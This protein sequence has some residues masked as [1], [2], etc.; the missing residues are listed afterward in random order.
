MIKTSTGPSSGRKCSAINSVAIDLATEI[1]F[2]VTTAIG[3][4]ERSRLIAQEKLSPQ[5]WP[6]LSDQLCRQQPATLPRR[7][8]HLSRA[9]ADSGRVRSSRC[10]G[11][12][13]Y[14]LTIID[15]QVFV[16]APAYA[17]SIQTQLG[18]LLWC[19]PIARRDAFHRKM[20]FQ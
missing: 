8:F 5:V 3:D 16:S 19:A 1:S 6:M 4:S 14:Q 2:Q 10:C 11:A 12:A 15:W 13:G 18:A 20:R 17:T 9:A 7:N